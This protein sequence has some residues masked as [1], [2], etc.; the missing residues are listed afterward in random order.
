M[1]V[2]MSKIYVVVASLRTQFG[3]D[4]IGD[5]G[6]VV[7]HV[8]FGFG[9]DHDAGEGF[10]AGVADDDAAGFGEVA[11]GGGDGLGD[12]G[13]LVERGLGADGY[14]DDGLRKGLE[15]GGEFGEGE[16]A[17]VDDVE[18]EERREEAV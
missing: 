18:D 17:A 10:G 9:F 5:G 15:V 11:L 3:A 1:I 2:R 7:V 13:D 4:G 12:R 8:G 14:V 16:A 6:G